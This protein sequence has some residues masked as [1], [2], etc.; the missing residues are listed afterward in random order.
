MADD[1]LERIV[2]V[3]HEEVAAARQRRSL[4]D[5]RAAAEQAGKGPVRPTS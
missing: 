5:I 2:A 1:I 3:K 4:A